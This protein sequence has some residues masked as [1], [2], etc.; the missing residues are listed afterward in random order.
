VPRSSTAQAAAQ[1]AE[2]TTTGET[3]SSTRSKLGRSGFRGAPGVAFAGGFQKDGLLRT[4]NYDQ[5]FF[6]QIPT[7]DEFGNADVYRNIPEAKP[8][9]G[10]PARVG[11]V[12]AE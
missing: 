7:E 10:N 9:T 12:A 5:V 1:S 6:A 11:Q 8:E 2:P 3:L 4:E